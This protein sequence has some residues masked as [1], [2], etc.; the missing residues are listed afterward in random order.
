MSRTKK[1]KQKKSLSVVPSNSRCNVGINKDVLLTKVEL[2]IS[3]AACQATLPSRKKPLRKHLNPLALHILPSA[4]VITCARVQRQWYEIGRS[5]KTKQAELLDALGG[6]G[7]VYEEASVP[8]T[9]VW[10]REPI[11]APKDTRGSLP[12]LLRPRGK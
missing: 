4:L 5:K 3:E 10:I 7:L 11:A 12:K 1:Q 9:P 8:P 6:E 2:A